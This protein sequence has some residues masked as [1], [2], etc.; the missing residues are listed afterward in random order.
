MT[1]TERLAALTAELEESGE[2][3]MEYNAGGSFVNGWGAREDYPPQVV[4]FV[5]RHRVAHGETLDECLDMLAKE[6]VA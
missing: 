6:Q 1:D 2:L 4:I 5:G 3:R